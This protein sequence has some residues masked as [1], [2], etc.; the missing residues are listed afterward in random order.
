MQ[1]SDKKN[2]RVAPATERNN[3][4]RSHAA[5]NWEDMPLALEGAKSSR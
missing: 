5:E 4:N 3:A 1:K 2:D